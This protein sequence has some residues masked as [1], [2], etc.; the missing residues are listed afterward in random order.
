MF[1]TQIPGK[2][3]WSPSQS[4]T[5]Q[6]LPKPVLSTRQ[7]PTE[8]YQKVKPIHRKVYRR[9]WSCHTIHQRP[10]WTVQTHL[11]N[12]LSWVFSKGTRTIKSLL[13][14]PK[15]SQRTYISYHWKC[16]TNNCTAESIGETNRSL[17]ERVSDHR[18][19][20]TGAIRNHHISTKHPKAELNDFMI[21]DRHSN[22]LHCQAKKAL[23]IHI[24]NPSLNRNIGKVRIPSAFNKLLKPSRQKELPHPG[25]T[26]LYLVFQYKRQLTLHTFLISIYNRNVIPMFTPF[27]LQDNWNLRSPPSKKHIGKQFTHITKC[28]LLQKVFK[29]QVLWSSHQFIKQGW[30]SN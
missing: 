18:N 4:P 11:S 7:T 14:H 5:R 16:P 24:K 3:N 22:T 12:I 26:L 8:N 25:G 20:T 13:K 30:R 9:S 1:Y 27:K 19:Q 17:K 29:L 28:H 23:H 21:K 15:D 6:P 10:Q 2:R